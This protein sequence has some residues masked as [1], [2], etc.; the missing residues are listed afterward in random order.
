MDAVVVPRFRRQRRPPSALAYN[1]GNF[2]RTLALRQSGRAKRPS[3]VSRVAKGRL[4]VRLNSEG[5]LGM[6]ISAFE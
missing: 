5:R 4:V 1:L 6:S 2:M 3:R